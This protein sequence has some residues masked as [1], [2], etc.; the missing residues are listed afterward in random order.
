M[1]LTTGAELAAA[2]CDGLGAALA[3]ARIGWRHLPVEDFAAPDKA[4]D[5]AWPVLAEE[6][7]AAL[8]AGRAVLLHCRGGIG[9]SGMITLRLLVERGEAPAAALRRLRAV[10]PGAVETEAQLAW[11]SAGRAG[12]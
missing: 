9:R 4:G 7:H 2:G 3:A 10:R 11:A 6:L 5:A 1:S 12:G 8:D